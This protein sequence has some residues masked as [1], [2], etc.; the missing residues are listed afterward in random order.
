MY[1]WSDEA[2]TAESSQ[3]SFQTVDG[4]SK[5]LEDLTENH[6]EIFALF[7]YTNHDDSLLRLFAEVKDKVT[8]VW[9]T[10]DAA[11]K[12]IDELLSKVQDSYFP[13]QLLTMTRLPSI[14]QVLLNHPGLEGATAETLTS[15]TSTQLQ[16]VSLTTMRSPEV[17]SYQGLP[18]DGPFPLFIWHPVTAPGSTESAILSCQLCMNR[19]RSALQSLVPELRPGTNMAEDETASATRRAEQVCPATE[20]SDLRETIA[21]NTDV[22]DED[23]DSKSGSGDTS[24]HVDSGNVPR[25]LTMDD[26]VIFVDTREHIDVLKE[27]L[28]LVNSESSICPLEDLPHLMGSEKAIVGFVGCVNVQATDTVLQALVS[29][30]RGIMSLCQSQLI[31]AVEVNYDLTGAEAT[32]HRQQWEPFQ[33]DI[34]DMLR[35]SW[36]EHNL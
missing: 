29:Q 35:E 3:C 20:H 34:D 33:P 19:F 26:V 28:D 27:V 5:T 9:I 2:S 15:R 22:S 36:R 7:E 14:T 4:T 11:A 12:Q 30:L 18:T 21:G 17:S 24:I 32:R 8:S 1:I 31:V 16:S 10:F 6:Q 23:S 25:P 13:V